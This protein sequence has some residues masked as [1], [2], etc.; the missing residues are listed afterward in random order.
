VRQRY[1][2]RYP[3]PAK[4][5]DALLARSSAGCWLCTP[6]AVGKVIAGR[7]YG[8][9]RH[10]H[11]SG[12]RPIMPQLTRAH[13]VIMVRR[14]SRSWTVRGLIKDSPTRSPIVGETYVMASRNAGS[15]C[16]S[17]RLASVWTPLRKAGWSA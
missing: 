5:P 2:N 7:R 16:I 15:C 1:C 17:Y 9:D 3:R 11:K 6:G 14:R 13:C 4:Q 8:H 10:V 12:A